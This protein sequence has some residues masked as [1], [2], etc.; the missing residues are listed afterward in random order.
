MRRS[1]LGAVSLFAFVAATA[2]TANAHAGTIWCYYYPYDYTIMCDNDSGGT[3]GHSGP[4]GGGTGVTLAPGHGSSIPNG[5]SNAIYRLF[6]FTTGVHLYTTSLTEAQNANNYYGFN[7]EQVEGVAPSGAGTEPLYRASNNTNGDFLYTTDGVEAEYTGGYTYNGIAFYVY[8]S[9][10]SGRCP[11]YRLYNN[12]N[13]MHYYT[14][15]PH[16]WYAAPSGVNQ[17]GLIG[18]V[19]PLSGY[20]C[21][22]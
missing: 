15:S 6:D 5:G 8:Y 20:S 22:N 7:F 3:N 2:W 13:G 14:I 10:G 1:V 11:L 12:Y 19:S 9:S 16:E 21:P 4:D 18:Y 17:E